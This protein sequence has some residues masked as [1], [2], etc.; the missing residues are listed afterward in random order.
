MDEALARR[1]L[2]HTEWPGVFFDMAEEEGTALLG[3]VH[4]S[5]PTFLLLDHREALQGKVVKGVYLWTAKG[6]PM[7]MWLLGA[8]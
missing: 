6:N 1:H 5:G 2:G 7:M 3:T 8:P 4:G